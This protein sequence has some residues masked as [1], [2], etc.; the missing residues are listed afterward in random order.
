MRPS[1]ED[2]PRELSNEPRQLSPQC[3]GQP[4][5]L[6]PAEPRLSDHRPSR[7]ALAQSQRRPEL[8]AP[9]RTGRTLL[10]PQTVPRFQGLKTRS[11]PRSAST[12]SERGPVLRITFPPGLTLREQ[13]PSRAFSI[14]GA[15][16]KGGR[17]EVLFELRAPTT[18]LQP[19]KAHGRA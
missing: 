14:T 16:G 6:I 13:P 7:W 12:A 2:P 19:S 15:E 8:C 4:P 18:S 17:G 1:L 10:Q 11:P 5:V 9:V 3:G